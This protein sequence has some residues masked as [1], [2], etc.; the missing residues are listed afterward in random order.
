MLIKPSPTRMHLDTTR[1][2]ESKI[3]YR[4][5]ITPRGSA[6][7]TSMVPISQ[8]PSRIPYPMSVMA[9]PP[10]PVSPSLTQRHSRS[11]RVSRS[12]RRVAGGAHRVTEV[13][14]SWNGNDM[15]V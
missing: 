1:S 15:L 4:S 14:Q 6:R 9:T 8:Q 2:P 10:R 11:R 3:R 7:Q 12:C 13:I 5:R